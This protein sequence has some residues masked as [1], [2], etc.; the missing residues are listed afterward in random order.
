MSLERER[1]AFC[2]RK[3]QEGTAAVQRA[4]FR[5]CFGLDL[6]KVLAGPVRGR[7]EAEMKIR[8][9]LRRERL[10]GA[11]G[12]H[13]YDINRQIALRQALRLFEENQ[14][15]QANTGGMQSDRRR[16]NQ[17]AA[18][19]PEDPALRGQRLALRPRPIF[20][21]SFERAAA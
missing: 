1:D 17:T 12:H 16:S 9:L 2:K 13:G 18:P 3:R 11:Q 4:A 10:K 5:L 8:R 20:L 14:A 21:A 6:E 7:R 19:R 15:G